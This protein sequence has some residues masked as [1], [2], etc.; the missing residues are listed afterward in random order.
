[1]NQCKDSQSVI[2]GPA[3]AADSIKNLLEKQALSSSPCPWDKES[4]CCVS[5]V[6]TL[7]PG[8]TKG[9][10]ALLVSCKIEAMVS[11]MFLFSC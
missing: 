11:V 7:T 2:P 3:A 9:K 5:L 4:E 10:N 6:P 8:N 1:M